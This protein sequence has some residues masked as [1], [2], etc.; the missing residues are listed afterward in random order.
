MSHSPVGRSD[1]VQRPDSAGPSAPQSVVPSPLR[2]LSYGS[3]SPRSP[4]S[5]SS[6][7]HL[8]TASS[9][10]FLGSVSVRDEGSP[11]VGRAMERYAGRPGRLAEVLVRI[12]AREGDP[13][14]QEEANAKLQGLLS[15][16]FV[17]TV[18]EVIHGVVRA[19]E[20][21]GL[22]YTARNVLASVDVTNLAAAA[23]GAITGGASRDRVLGAIH[24]LDYLASK[25]NPRAEEALLGIVNGPDPERAS[26]AIEH[27]GLMVEGGST[28]AAIFLGNLARGGNSAALNKL[29]DLAHRDLEVAVNELAAVGAHPGLD[30]AVAAGIVSDLSDAA[31]GTEDIVIKGTVARAMQ[32]LAAAGVEE[33]KKVLRGE[34]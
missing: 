15:S 9:P 13:K 8:A 23:Q 11:R 18:R 22:A 30:K 14:A 1:R 10:D 16:P 21:D 17:A 32:T 12:A 27:L 24:S 3:V 4:V 20:R 2:D 6:G 33:A 26:E 7:S 19:G 34:L 29:S 28:G 25:G 31:L 5:V